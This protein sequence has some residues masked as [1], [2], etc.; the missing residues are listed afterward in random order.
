[1][2]L[3]NNKKKNPCATNLTPNLVVDTT[4]VTSTDAAENKKT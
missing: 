2:E 4:T 1:M 3:E